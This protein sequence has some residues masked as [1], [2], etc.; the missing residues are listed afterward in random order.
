[1]LIL[2]R[3]VGEKINL[4]VHYSRNANLRKMIHQ[5]GIDPDML[6]RITDTIQFTLDRIE[7]VTGCEDELIVGIE[8]GRN[9]D[10]VR[11][12]IDRENI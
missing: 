3:R 9:V 2:S 5:L 4:K 12:E 7:N 8:A 6:G 10:I 1:M 11:S